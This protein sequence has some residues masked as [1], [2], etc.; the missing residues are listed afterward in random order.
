M[1]AKKDVPY[2]AI[3]RYRTGHPEDSVI[4]AVV[5]GLVE[6]QHTVGARNDALTDHER[7]HGWGHNLEPMAGSDARG[8]LAGHWR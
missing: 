3:R 2:Y 1:G 7:A 8:W 6:V 4:V 5:R